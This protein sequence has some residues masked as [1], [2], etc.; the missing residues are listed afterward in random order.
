[1]S[2]NDLEYDHPLKCKY[3]AGKHMVRVDYFIKTS[4]EKA[5]LPCRGYF[6]AAA[7]FYMISISVSQASDFLAG[8]I[9][10]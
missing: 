8:F 5:D 10:V 3:L 2:K 9:T 6:K 7:M 1:M 4:I